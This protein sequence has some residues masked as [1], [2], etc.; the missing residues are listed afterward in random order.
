MSSRE[1]SEAL[2]RFR[3]AQR[4]A[5]SSAVQQRMDLGRLAG[6]EFSG[7]RDMWKTLGYPETVEIRFEKFYGQYRRGGVAGKIID[8]PAQ[9]TWRR[10]VEIVELDEQNNPVQPDGLTPWEQDVHALFSSLSADKKFER[11]DRVCGIGRYAILV[12]GSTKSDGQL[13]RPITEDAISGP[14]DIAFLSVFR[15]DHAQIAEYVDDETNPRFGDPLLYDVTF[16]EGKS[17]STS[18]VRRVHFSRVIHVAEDPLEDDVFGRPRLERVYNHLC[19]LLKVS[20]GSAEMFW[21]N[22]G[23]MLWGKVPPGTDVETEDKSAEEVLEDVADKILAAMHQQRRVYFSQGLED[24]SYLGASTPD[25]SGI[26]E[27]LRALISSAAN[28]PESVLFGTARGDV[29][30]STDLAEWYG[31]I[32]ERQQRF[33]GPV[34]VRPL[35]DRMITLGVLKPPAHAYRASWPA[36]AELDESEHATV[37]EKRANAVKAIANALALGDP[38][39]VE[40]LRVLMPELDGALANPDAAALANFLAEEEGASRAE[41]EQFLRRRRVRAG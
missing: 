8:A 6:K 30:K 17:S 13:E 34:I 22:V 12:I 26:W 33:A 32:G 11:V 7:D 36:L 1:A 21:A 10:G 31:R 39:V 41:I 18:M 37:S 19:D 20:G 9:T 24:L 25:P 2:E 23:G 28:I 29:A 14:D 38:R 4:V 3:L 5:R 35:I 40:V 16:R 27:M 15:E